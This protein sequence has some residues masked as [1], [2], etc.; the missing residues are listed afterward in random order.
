MNVR[1][2]YSSTQELLGEWDQKK[3]SVILEINILLMTLKQAIKKNELT[4]DTLN[5]NKTI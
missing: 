2:Q 1:D 4:C 3:T 5:S